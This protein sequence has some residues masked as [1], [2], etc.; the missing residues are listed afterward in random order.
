MSLLLLSIF[1]LPNELLVRWTP[2]E[3]NHQIVI[4]YKCEKSEGHPPFT[5]YNVWPIEPDDM[6]RTFRRVPTPLGQKC[7]IGV[8]VLR[9]YEGWDGD[10]STLRVG[11]YN[12]TV[13]D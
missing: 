9:V 12:L 6:E 5:A 13:M 3:D 4:V 10:E 8:H 2:H 1:L 11:E 7:W